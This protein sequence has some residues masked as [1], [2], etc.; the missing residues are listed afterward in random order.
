MPSTDAVGPVRGQ[1][2]GPCAEM[3]SPQP[4]CSKRSWGLC[5]LSSPPL[6]GQATPKRPRGAIFL[7]D[8]LHKKTAAI[9]QDEPSHRVCVD[10]GHCPTAEAEHTPQE[11]PRDL[12]VSA[13]QGALFREKWACQNPCRSSFFPCPSGHGCPP[14]QH[15]GRARREAGSQQQANGFTWT[16][17]CRPAPV[18]C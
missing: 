9:G 10:D 2:V 13:Q 16:S 1:A 5:F 8:H 14:A 3:L 6:G 17:R 4:V 18:R 12:C 11:R 15:A 7:K